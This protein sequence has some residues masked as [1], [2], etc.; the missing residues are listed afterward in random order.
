MRSFKTISALI[1]ASSLVAL[2][3]L[4]CSCWVGDQDFAMPMAGEQHGCCREVPAQ[5]GDSDS[6]SECCEQCIARPAA[7]MG[8][9]RAL[10]TESPSSR[11]IKLSLQAISHDTTEPKLYQLSA[12]ERCESIFLSSAFHTVYSP[13]APP[14]A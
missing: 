4:S 7:T 10:S 14:T 9:D 5:D 1:V 11:F 13:R 2:P 6:H 3:L 12:I 8:V